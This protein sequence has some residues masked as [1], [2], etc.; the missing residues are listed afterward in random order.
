[1]ARGVDVGTVNAR[2]DGTADKNKV[3]RLE[4]ARGGEV[5]TS[6]FVALELVEKKDKTHARRRRH[7]KRERERSVN[8]RVNERE[9]RL[10]RGVPRFVV[11][12]SKRK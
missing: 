4:R 1:M 8:V 9:G 12:S 3:A 6:H 11:L 2:R 10:D 7:G 5:T